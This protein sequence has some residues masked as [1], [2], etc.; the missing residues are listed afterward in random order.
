MNNDVNTFCIYDV[1]F[2]P[3]NRNF[4]DVI[5]LPSH[6]WAR[7]KRTRHLVTNFEKKHTLRNLIYTHLCFPKYK[8]SIRY[9]TKHFVSESYICKL[10][11]LLYKKL[12]NDHNPASTPWLGQHCNKLD[13]VTVCMFYNFQPWKLVVGR[14]Q[15]DDVTPM[16]RQLLKNRSDVYN[17]EESPICSLVG[18]PLSSGRQCLDMHGNASPSFCQRHPI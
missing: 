17:Y 18:V 10:R 4:V 15:R 16:L 8:C 6:T 7:L 1:I 14:R 13:T 11:P 3:V 9:F 2:I 12:V 5:A